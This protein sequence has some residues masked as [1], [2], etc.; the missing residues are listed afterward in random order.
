MIASFSVLKLK[1]VASR[2]YAGWRGCSA[3]R[4]IAPF[5]VSV[6]VPVWAVAN[7]VHAKNASTANAR[8]MCFIWFGLGF[9]CWIFSCWHLA[10]VRV[11]V[12]NCR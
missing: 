4:F 7:V 8:L 5:L 3:L 9:C 12:T 11:N 2:E 1:F 10:I 6:A